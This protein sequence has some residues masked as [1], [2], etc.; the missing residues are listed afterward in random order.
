[1]ALP[2]EVAVGGA[3][4][5]PI[6]HILDHA[7]CCGVRQPLKRAP[8]QSCW[9]PPAVPPVSASPFSVAGSPTSWQ[10][11]D[12]ERCCGLR[13][14]RRA[15]PGGRRNRGT[16]S[17]V[18][19]S[20]RLGFW[21]LVG[22]E[23]GAG[24]AAQLVSAIRD[25]FEF[26]HARERAAARAVIRKRGAEQGNNTAAMDEEEEEEEVRS[27]EVVLAVLCWKALWLRLVVSDTVGMP[28]DVD[29]AVRRA[30]QQVWEP[31][32]LLPWLDVLSSGW[33]IFPLLGRLYDQWHERLDTTS[34]AGSAVPPTSL[35][36]LKGRRCMMDD[37][38]EDEVCRD[39]PDI[40]FMRA[41]MM[42][43]T[44]WQQREDADGSRSWGMHD[45][46]DHL[47][48][49]Q[50]LLLRHAL[51]SGSSVSHPITMDLRFSP[52]GV[53]TKGAPRS[54][55]GWRNGG[56]PVLR[57]LHGLF[58]QASFEDG[59]VL[60]EA[61]ASARAATVRP[62][63]GRACGTSDTEQEERH[64]MALRFPVVLDAGA[65]VG[66][67]TL[68]F[69]RRWP[70]GVVFAVE[71]SAA[72]FRT[73]RKKVANVSNVQALRAALAGETHHGVRLYTG[74]SADEYLP[75]LPGLASQATLLR[76]LPAHEAAWGV[77]MSEG[78][79]PQCHNTLVI[80]D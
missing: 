41:G 27:F 48:K 22:R 38:E 50:M 35:N 66:T 39:S 55:R 76:P 75:S 20:L 45:F 60:A 49:A 59:S 63:C 25:L 57:L 44:A 73:L 5:Y 71:P 7:T 54:V 8:P 51:A 72:V 15:E 21:G 24:C 36:Y 70:S 30:F 19:A 46:P 31:L 10:R 16:R 78:A 58:W 6:G 32:L 53:D 52:V 14:R 61:L 1:M 12:Q 40:L 69:S 18:A 65:H 77:R 33:P 23:C 29:S 74:S 80:L 26:Y 13:V 37:H 28:D 2:F 17:M 11:W 42:L 43:Y 62:G 64:R 68:T 3:G 56:W 34:I 79:V 67:D 4:C 9:R 47:H